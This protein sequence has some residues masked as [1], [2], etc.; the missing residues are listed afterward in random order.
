MSFRKEYD[1]FIAYHGSYESGGSRAYADKLY[2]FLQSKG[3]RCFYFPF[4]NKDVY[5]ANII[6]VMKSRMFILVCTDKIHV[7]ESGRIDTAYHY[8]LSTEI[9]AFYALTQIGSVP[10]LNAKVLVCGEYMK[11]DECRLHELF[12]NRTHIYEH[13]NENVWNEIY[14][15]IQKQLTDSVSWQDSQLTSEIKAV[16]ATR[17]AMKETC[18]F[19]NLVAN[20]K[21][22]KAVGISNS[23]LTSKINPQAIEHCIKNGGEL[24]ILFLKPDGMFTS[25][26]EQEEGLRPD[27]I[28]VISEINIE[29]AWGLKQSLQEYS[30][31]Y[32]IYVYDK[33]PRLNMIFIDDCLILQYYANN[34]PG[35]KNPAFFVEKQKSSPV[36]EFCE[37]EFEY[38][39]SEAE[40]VQSI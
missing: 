22:I 16:F 28:K 4:V 1:V 13:E 29:T 15:W 3:L 39:K 25:L 31:N 7:T 11:G 20:A 14:E 17:A 23:E 5:K 18:N 38:L 21:K 30:D 33:Q 2:H 19:D 10:L 34:V 6:E 37:K 9:D 27:R 35:L 40:L 32:R 12:A 8:E 24:E 36:F 26:R